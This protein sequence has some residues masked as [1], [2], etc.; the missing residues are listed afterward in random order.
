MDFA[1]RME[2]RLSQTIFAQRITVTTGVQTVSVLD[3]AEFL[4]RILSFAKLKLKGKVTTGDRTVNASDPAEFLHK[5]LR[6]VSNS[7][8]KVTTINSRV[9][10]TINISNNKAT[11]I[12]NILTRA[13]IKVADTINS[14][15]ITTTVSIVVSKAQEAT[16]KILVAL[17]RVR[18]DFDL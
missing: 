5:I 15:V 18:F 16:R 7:N 17:F 8:N 12:T 13:V 9:I 10:P 14:N 11:H 6:C 2:R 4:R 1:T 3:L